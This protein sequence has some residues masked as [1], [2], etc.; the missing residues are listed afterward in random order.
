[1]TREKQVWTVHT[2]VKISV[3]GVISFVLTFFKTPVWFT[4]PFLKLDIADVPSLLGAFAMGP[5]TGIW[6]PLIK[7]LLNVVVEG[8]V[9]NGIGELTNFLEGSVMAY[10]AGWVY[11]RNRTFKGA[12]L[13]LGLG[14]ISMTVFATLNNHFVMFPLYG[15]V[16]GIDRDTLVSLASAGNGLVADYTTLLLF[17]IVPFNLLKGLAASVVAVLVYKRLSP[18]LK[19]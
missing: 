10:T 18:V 8:T 14:V 4:L 19:G 3:L 7:N 9:T 13:G 5:V 15:K 16:F 12:L 17:S 6:V 1:M 2:L 11:K